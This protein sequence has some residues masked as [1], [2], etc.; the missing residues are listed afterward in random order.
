MKHVL[1]I[2][3]VL[4]FGPH[5]YSQDGI[6]GPFDTVERL[7]ITFQDSRGDLSKPQ[8]HTFAL[9]RNA[10]PP[11]KDYYFTLDDV[12]IADKDIEEKMRECYKSGSEAVRNFRTVPP[13][14]PRGIEN[15]MS[16]SINGQ[17]ASV[18]LSFWKGAL[19]ENPNLGALQRLLE[20]LLS[21]K[22]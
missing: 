12:R 9:S 1:L 14:S 13:T 16:I 8:Y 5:V 18:S 22:K 6:F 4:L 19:D 3:F 21:D 20:T 7:S 10:W 17:P 11:S 15:F 2:A